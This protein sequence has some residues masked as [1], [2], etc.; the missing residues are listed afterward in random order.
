MSPHIIQY[1]DQLAIRLLFA[2]NRKGKSDNIVCI[3][4]SNVY[5]TLHGESK[6]KEGCN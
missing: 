6:G 5:I 2:L 3:Y 4:Y 1:N